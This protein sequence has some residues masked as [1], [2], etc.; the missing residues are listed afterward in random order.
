M[1]CIICYSI[2]VIILLLEKRRKKK[3]RKKQRGIERISSRLTHPFSSPILLI[4]LYFK[5]LNHFVF[6]SLWCFF[7]FFL[8]LKHFWP[9]DYY[10]YVIPVSKKHIPFGRSSTYPS[11]KS[12]RVKSCSKKC[13]VSSK[14]KF[15]LSFILN[16]WTHSPPLPPSLFS[17]TLGSW[18]DSDS[19]LIFLS[20]LSD[21][22]IS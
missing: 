17:F 10:K 13:S 9:P 19:W 7:L 5:R 21:M 16:I 3:K 15:L 11:R 1:I 8:I 6:L 18:A 4:F 22:I 20:V 12:T 14:L 2:L